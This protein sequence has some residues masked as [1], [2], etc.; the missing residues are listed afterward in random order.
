MFP[1]ASNQK[2][3]WIATMDDQI[4]KFEKKGIYKLVDPPKTDPKYQDT[5]WQMGLCC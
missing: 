2:E 3:H 4:A 5:S 1:R